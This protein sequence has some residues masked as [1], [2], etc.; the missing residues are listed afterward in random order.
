MALDQNTGV[1]PSTQTNP[2]EPTLNEEQIRAMRGDL[3]PPAVAPVAE[4]QI[5]IPVQPSMNS[6]KVIFDGE[7]PAFS[8]NTTTQIPPSVD[9]LIAQ[10]GSRKTLWWIIG[11][12]VIVAA[13]GGVGYFY[14]YPMLATPPVAPIVETPVTPQPPTPPAPAVPKRTS[15][16]INSPGQE[17]LVT[18]ASPLSRAGILAGIAEQTKNVETGVVELIFSSDAKTPI[19][20]G[21]F[22]SAITP[23][24]TAVAKT[25]LLFVDDFTAYAYK[26]D[27]G[28]WPGY[29]ANLKPDFNQEKDGPELK[30]WFTSLEKS[31]L[32]NFFM[33]D[34]G[35]MGAFKD[36]MINEKYPDRYSTGATAGASFGYAAL[37]PTQQK[38]VISTSFMG[39]KEAIRLMGL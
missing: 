32:K 20:F 10:H 8:P 31:P 13:L 18:L 3:N 1:G 14:V 4:P 28:V 22:L 19:A 33:A 30:A 27:K 24:F 38:V 2:T 35:K 29:V 17:G 7:E 9:N 5:S 39:L 11:G 25:N 23:E 34:P 6:T 12:I 26:D 37:L 16:F 36:G 21:P 15:S